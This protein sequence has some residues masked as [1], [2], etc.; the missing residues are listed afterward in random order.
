MRIN[1]ICAQVRNVQIN[2]F[3][4][5]LYNLTQQSIMDSRYFVPSLPI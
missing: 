2:P 3:I 4:F 5:L 1:N